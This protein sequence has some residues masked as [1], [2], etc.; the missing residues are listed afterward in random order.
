MGVRHMAYNGYL[1]KIGN[2]TVPAKL[3]KAES[4]SAY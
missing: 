2:Y 3:I 1:L 4:Y